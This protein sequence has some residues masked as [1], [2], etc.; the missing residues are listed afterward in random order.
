M[1]FLADMGIS[2]K[3]VVFLNS[4][5]YDATH[6]RDSNLERLA[7]PEVLSKARDEQRILLTHDLDFGELLA[8]SGADLPSVIIFRLQNMRPERVNK[9]MLALINSYEDVLTS[10]AILSITDTKVRIR[11]LPIVDK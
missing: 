5:G 4:Q 9:T 10:G 8:A 3:T 6:L 11:G 1:R 2:P 7:D